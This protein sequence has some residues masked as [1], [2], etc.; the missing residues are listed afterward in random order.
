MTDANPSP[1]KIIP[2][3]FQKPNWIVDVVMRY[4]PGEH[5]KCLDV[6]VRKTLGWLKERDR[7]AT[8]QIV[9]L[10]GYSEKTVYKCM[11]ELCSFGLVLKTD[12]NNAKN[13]GNEW[14]LQLEDRLVDLSGLMVWNGSLRSK[15]QKRTSK[16]RASR[17]VLLSHN[18]TV[19]T[20]Q[21]GTVVTQQTQKP[22]SKANISHTQAAPDFSSM[23][24]SDAYKVPAL[25]LYKRATGFFPGSAAWEYVHTFISENKLTEEQIKK[26]STEWAIQGYKQTNVKGI[27]EWARDGVPAAPV[28]GSAK[29]QRA[30]GKAK[31]LSD[32]DLDRILGD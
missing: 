14:S 11:K 18:G 12:G 6:V 10:T 4:L 25:Q 20:Q 29:A 5:Y 15:N 1:S 32:D 13:Q 21:S 9:T 28:R 30:A 8:S 26:A 31:K 17:G 27:L 23:S 24:V 7:I 19:V 16:A 3:S 2:N 22:L